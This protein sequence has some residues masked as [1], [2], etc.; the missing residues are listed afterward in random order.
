MNRTTP[1]PDCPRSDAV[2][3]R[4]L[5]GDVDDGS[6]FALVDD[7]TLRAHLQDCAACRRQL[8]RARR[9]DAVLA[10]RVGT[11]GRGELDPLAQRWF[12][13]VTAATPATVAAA[14][15]A[16]ATVTPANVA[17]VAVWPAAALLVLAVLAAWS[18]WAFAAAERRAAAEVC[19]SLPATGLPDTG[20]PA[21]CRSDVPAAPTAAAA[22]PLR[23]ASVTDIEVAGGT[24]RRRSRPPVEAPAPDRRL[25]WR[26]IGDRSAP[27]EQRLAAL[28]QVTPPRAPLPTHAFLDQLAVLAGLGDRGGG[29]RE[30]HGRCLALVR[31]DALFQQQLRSALQLAETRRGAPTDTDLAA[32]TVAARLGVPTLDA[33]LVRLMRRHPE[34]PPV[35]AAALRCGA[36][37]VG[38]ADLLLDVWHDLVARGEIADTDAAPMAWFRHQP[39]HVFDEVAAAL[40]QTGSSPQ[41]VRCLLALGEASGAPTLQLLLD[42]L[43]RGSF[44]ESHA[45]AF[46][47]A[48]RPRHELADLAAQCQDDHLLRAALARAGLPATVDW[49]AA[50]GLDAEAR[51]LLRHGSF[52]EFPRVAGWF[53]G[54]VA[55]L[56]D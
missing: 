30:L 51:A 48:H 34:R 29:E 3:A 52:A 12:A 47:L 14:T 46:A 37:A 38:A 41:R 31:G 43:Q 40:A 23:Q 54:T 11:A 56:D 26:T 32:L 18:T 17:R 24:L 53:R 7:A 50:L 10:A 22:V 25:A 49:L 44:L 16:P 45:A 20:L 15:V 9:L 39:D 6:G 36:R 8:Q 55:A 5:D 2:L 19:A 27:T 4:F 35:L 13:A 21:G 42:W 1:S 33:A 28:A